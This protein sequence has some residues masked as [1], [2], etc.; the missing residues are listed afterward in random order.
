MQISGRNTIK[1]RKSGPPTFESRETNNE[2]HFSFHGMSVYIFVHVCL[3]FF[4]RR[5]WWSANFR[6]QQ[7]AIIFSFFDDD[8]GGGGGDDVGPI[9]VP[10]RELFD[11]VVFL[12][13]L[14][15]GEKGRR[16]ESVCFR[17]RQQAAFV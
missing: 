1:P 3:H 7:A 6:G 11:V 12:G 2:M 4:F 5:W 13:G 8:D 9:F 14:V 16:M 17:Y 15:S 10:N